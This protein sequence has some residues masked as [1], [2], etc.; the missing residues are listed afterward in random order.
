MTKNQVDQQIAQIEATQEA[1]RNSI[2][3]TKRLSKKAET[4][5]Q[6]HKKTLERN[7]FGH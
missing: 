7:Q 6:E 5:L 1:L 3:A 2:E 4:L